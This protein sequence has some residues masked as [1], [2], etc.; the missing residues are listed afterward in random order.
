MHVQ[1]A[2]GFVLAL[3]LGVMWRRLGLSA[4]HG[5]A[6]T[7]TVVADVFLRSLRMVIVPLIF[8][9]IVSAV[10]AL[11]VRSVGRMGARTFGFFALTTLLSVSVGLLLVNLIRPGDGMEV[12]TQAQ[13]LPEPT[14][15]SEVL[16]GIVPENPIAS[17]AE[18]FDLLGVIF[19]ALL[20]GAAM[21]ALGDEA[22]PA[23]RLFDSLSAVMLKITSWVLVL[24]P[25]GIF[26]LVFGVV[27]TT[28]PSVFISMLSYVVTVLLGLAIHAFV[29]LPLLM[30]ALTGVAAWR[31][32][33]LLTPTL[34][35]G[36][37]TASSAAALPLA[38]EAMEQDAN[39]DKR[40]VG[41][42]MPL[43]S[44]VN[45][46]GT[47]LY[48]AVA[49]LF[50]AQAYGIDL[51]L[52]QQLIVLATA[53]L[54]AVGAAGVPSAGLVMLILVLEAVGLPLEGIAL[55]LAVD[56]LLDMFR[57]TLNLWGDC[58]TTVVVAYFEG[59]IADTPL[60]PRPRGRAKDAA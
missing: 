44:T 48:E 51:S 1:V 40:A 7:M 57:T 39:I 53:L 32:L 12:A 14:P 16:L 36:F 38:L 49:A 18:T 4:D 21:S 45:M 2:I 8:S 54:A 41:F 33:R 6:A 24:A 35:T 29:V 50:I 27:V 11:P 34:L 46:D 43:G 19:F 52:S 10:A 15:F 23:K 26:A 28:G 17:M 20:L 47:A 56:R 37:S 9:T 25:L 13:S 58:V 30:W 3:A 5:F 42:V 31:L 22:A 60:K 55:L 59:M